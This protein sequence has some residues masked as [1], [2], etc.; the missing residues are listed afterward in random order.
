MKPLARRLLFLSASLWVLSVMF[1][2]VSPAWADIDG[3]CGAAFKGV[4]IKGR[5]TSSASDA[6]DVDGDE[7]VG[8]NMTSPA[9]FTSHKVELEIAGV[10]RTISNKTDGGDTQW[11][12]IVNVK[13][14]AWAGAGLYM[15]TGSATLTDGSTCSGSALINVTRFP[16]TTV[17]G[18]AAAAAAVVGLLAVAATSV[19][20]ARDG[21]K[22]SAKVE[23][24]VTNEI[25]KVAKQDKP[26][27]PE[28]TIIDE[29]TW[30]LSGPFGPCLIMAIPGLILTGAAMAM[31][32]GGQPAGG[33]RLRRARWLPRVTVAGVLGGLLAGLG[34]AVL[35]QQ[36]AVAPLTRELLIECLIGGVIIGI[37]LPSL[38][39]L[40]SVLRVNAGVRRAEQRLRAALAAKSG[41]PQS[42]PPP[43]ESQT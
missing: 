23:D 7:V 42:P 41:P 24:W 40:W 34:S 12:D 21:A 8:V 18:G 14:Y 43:A 22:A 38:G 27:E 20:S 2:L 33:R 32:Q 13:D 6:I 9:G 25:E 11:S 28:W 31:P 37:A 5:G 29:I 17:A 39:K 4:D 26:P 10:S 16:L 30:H 36:F 1:P 15:V 35:L 19:V 3:N